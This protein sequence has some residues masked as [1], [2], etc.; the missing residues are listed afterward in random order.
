MGERLTP[1]EDEALETLHW[2]E[3]FGAELAAAHRQLK[4]ELLERDLRSVVRGPRADVVLGDPAD[5]WP[6]PADPTSDGRALERLA[7]QVGALERRVV[8]LEDRLG[9]PRTP[10]F[11]TRCH[12]RYRRSG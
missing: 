12:D 7:E 2:L 11:R 9:R 6:P 3:Y 1:D 4:A 10:A 5:D 8:E